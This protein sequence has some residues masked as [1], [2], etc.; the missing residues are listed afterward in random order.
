MPDIYFLLILS[1][2]T[3]GTNIDLNVKVKAFD[4]TGQESDLPEDG[5]PLIDGVGTARL[6][7]AVPLADL[8]AGEIVAEVSIGGQVVAVSRLRIL[9]ES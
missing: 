4:E 1:G 5:P 7:L 9:D 3:S 8:C 2:L 6:R